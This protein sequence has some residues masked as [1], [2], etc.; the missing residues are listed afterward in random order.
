MDNTALI[1]MMVMAGFRCTIITL[2][3]DLTAKQVT[4]AR[5]RLKVVS[6]G[7]SGPLPLGSRILSSKARII[8]AALFMG[9]YLRGA[10]SPLLGIDVEATIAAHQ[11]YLTYRDVLRLNPAESLS[12]D[13]A[14]VIAREYR[15]KDVV[16]RVCRKC[17]LTYVALT[18]TN[19]ST[20]PY[21]SQVVVKDRFHCDVIDAAMSERPA[22]ELLAL[23]LNIQQ[24]TNWG[25]SAH[26]IM[27]QLELNQSEYLAG[28]ELLEHK[29]PDRR[30]MVE[31]YPVGDH[32]VR[33]LVTRD[34]VPALR[35]A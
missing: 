12:I 23:A 19:K 24:L 30:A 1:D 15:S 20:C 34:S 18:S 14:W 2:H 31:L 4:S 21:C 11:S 10:R 27:T 32:L 26:E 5:K 13:E 6:R 17:D 16:M 33:A 35:S 25:Y 29:E 22:E 3:T 9:A 7:G 8:E 28:L